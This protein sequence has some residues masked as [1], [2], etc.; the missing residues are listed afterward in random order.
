MKK[1]RY[2]IEWTDV[3]ADA[4]KV[5]RAAQE[6]P[7]AYVRAESSAE[8]YRRAYPEFFRPLPHR[9]ARRKAI[10]EGHW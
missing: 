2:P 8:A 9:L 3:D 6:V 5:Q 1:P 10:R 7:S 4:P